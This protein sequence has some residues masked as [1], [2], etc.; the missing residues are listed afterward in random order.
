MALPL[1]LL[2]AGTRRSGG[3]R[4]R[5]GGIELAKLACGKAGRADA[6]CRSFDDIRPVPGERLTA[7]GVA[8]ESLPREERPR[9]DLELSMP[10]RSVAADASNAGTPEDGRESERES[11]GVLAAPASDL[12]TGLTAGLIPCTEGMCGGGELTSGERKAVAERLQSGVLL[13]E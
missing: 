13:H 2:A 1:L 7:V 10:P 11:S 5:A 8:R 3:G 6:P 9:D 4:R 12:M